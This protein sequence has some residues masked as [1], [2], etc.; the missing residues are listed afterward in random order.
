MDPAR[1]EARRASLPSEIPNEMI[2]SRNC[3]RYHSSKHMQVVYVPLTIS[4]G[5][6][7]VDSQ[8]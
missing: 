5:N 1:I 8:P 7:R 2:D 6:C 3:P 4:G